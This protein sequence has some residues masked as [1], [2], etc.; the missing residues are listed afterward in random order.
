MN[1]VGPYPPLQTVLRQQPLPQL[2]P[3]NV[4]VEIGFFMIA[5]LLYRP[6]VM[7][8]TTWL[9]L[10]LFS[11]TI[12]GMGEQPLSFSSKFYGPLLHLA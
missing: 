8:C 10:Q 1:P 2:I 12:L 4:R 6:W 9:P 3:S 7:G 5:C 11:L